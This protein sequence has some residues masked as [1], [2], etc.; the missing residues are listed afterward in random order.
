MLQKL[1][2]VVGAGAVA[3]VAVAA[4]TPEHA[5]ARS[6]VPPR[7]VSPPTIDD[8]TPV[9]GQTLIASPGRWEGT[10]PFSFS[11]QWQRCNSLGQACI[12]VGAG[13]ARYR[14]RPAD[15]TFRLRVRVTARNVDGRRSAVSATTDIVQPAAPAPAPGSTIPVTSVS[16]PDRLV[17]DTVSFSPAPITSRTAQ[18]TVRVRVKD[19][20]GFVISGALVFIRP[21]PLVTNAPAEGATGADGFATFAVVPNRNFSLIYRRGFN[22]P[23]FVRAR[24]LG[25]NPLAGVS[26][27]RL[28]QVRIAPAR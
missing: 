2:L 6:M 10:Q 21:V 25:D 18:I 1:L 11:Y 16:P 20:R 23:F 17:V 28:V 26:S 14:V 19:T 4:V 27:R 3:A 8:T 13:T 5:P 12:A 7:N 9:Q 22:L 15:V 24:K